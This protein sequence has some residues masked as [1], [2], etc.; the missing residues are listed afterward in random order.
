[1]DNQGLSPL[2]ARFTHRG[3]DIGRSGGLVLCTK[4]KSL[5][6]KTLAFFRALRVLVPVHLRKKKAPPQKVLFFLVEY[7]Q[8]KSN[9]F[10]RTKN[11]TQSGAKF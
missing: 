5:A 10:G 8:S 4:E 7:Y 2:A 1:M 6:Q 9:T 3:R 11:P